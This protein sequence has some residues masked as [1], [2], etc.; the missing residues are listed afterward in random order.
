MKNKKNI[1]LIS[2]PL[3]T[4]IIVIFSLIFLLKQDK[5]ISLNEENSGKTFKQEYEKLNNTKDSEG[6]EYPK[7]NIS[8]NNIIKYSYEQ[9]ILNIFTNKQDGVVYFG[10]PSCLYCR[11]SVEVL[12]DTAEKTKL[13]EIYY[14]DTEKIDVSKELNNIL[15]ESITEEEYTSLVIFITDGEIVSYNIDT[16][17]SHNNPYNNLNDSQKEGLSEIYRYGINDVVAS[18]QIKNN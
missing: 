1:I 15:K 8:S 11:S 13:D 17:S 7:I 9:E 10:Y 3:I 6:K 4:L 12:L 18:K 2:L 14:I 5:K 16:L